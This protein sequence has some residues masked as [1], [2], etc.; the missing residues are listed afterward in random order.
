[1]QYSGPNKDFGVPTLEEI[2][3]T[4]PHSPLKHPGGEREALRRLDVFLADK[5]Q[6]M[7]VRF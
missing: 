5:K 2:G 6:A 4:N 1:M 7:Q 3:R